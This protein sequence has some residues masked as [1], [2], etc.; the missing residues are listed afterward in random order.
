MREVKLQL[1]NGEVTLAI[2]VIV[3]ESIVV[4][5]IGMIIRIGTVEAIGVTIRLSRRGNVG[6]TAVV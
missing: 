6:I 5:M 1:R 3:M 4:G 2:I